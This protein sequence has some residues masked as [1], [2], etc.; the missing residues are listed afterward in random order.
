VYFGDSSFQTGRGA[1]GWHKDNRVVDRFDH[2]GQDWD[3]RYPLIRIGVY[4]QD[5][6]HYSGGLGI[7]VGSHE[8]FWAAQLPF[9]PTKLQKKVTLWHGKPIHVATEPGDLAVWT[10]RTTHTGNSVRIKPAPW[11]KLP[12][13]LEDKV[14]AWLAMDE[15]Q[16]RAAMFATYAARSA[17]LD[18]YLDYWKT[19][20]YAKE[21]LRNSRID[22]VVRAAAK[23]KGLDVM[24][25]EA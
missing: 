13:G 25:I 3:G 10:L 9:L 16:K 6:A 21:M 24:K 7:R 15:E 1:R 12:T 23:Q 14:P 5:H 2:R 4:L 19:R 8:P 11:L 17:H 18:R 20:D 22:D